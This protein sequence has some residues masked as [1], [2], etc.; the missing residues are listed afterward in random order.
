MLYYAILLKQYTSTEEIQLVLTQKRKYNI[1]E[2]DSKKV[3]VGGQEEKCTERGYEIIQLI[4][5]VNEK[6]QLKRRN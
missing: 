3:S 5:E 1:R 2:K 4:R 6:T